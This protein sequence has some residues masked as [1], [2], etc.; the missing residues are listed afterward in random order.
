MTID[1]NIIL[2]FQVD[3]LNSENP[4]D[5]E[6]YMRELI[7]TL[8]EMYTNIA[9]AVNGSIGSDQSVGLQAYTPIVTGTGGTNGAETYSKQTGWYLRQGIIVDVWVDLAFTGHTGTGNTQINLP[10]TSA[11]TNNDPFV[12]TLIA[13][14]IA[15]STNY[16]QTAWSVGSDTTTADVLES[17]SGQTL[18]SLPL[19]AAASFR[20]HLRYIGQ[21]R[22]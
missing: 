15:Y 6:A 7:V 1:S 4:R 14:T 16:T 11:I 5:R 19:A 13:G 2:P 9:Q 21:E 18:Q 20:G 17:G 10:Y 12:G 3:R 22:V 8:E